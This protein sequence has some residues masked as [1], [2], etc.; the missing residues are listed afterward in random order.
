[1]ILTDIQMIESA[2]SINQ[3]EGRNVQ[4]YSKHCYN[5]LY[6]KYKTDSAK[7]KSSIEFYQK[8]PE[9]LETIYK[10]V[11]DSLG[12]K[13]TELSSKAVPSVNRPQ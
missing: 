12:K 9:Q 13:Q 7:I 10:I 4:V 2:I 11:L 6:K 1:M 3:N 5:Y 8:N